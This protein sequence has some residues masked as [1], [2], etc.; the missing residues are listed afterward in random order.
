[1]W[2][3]RGIGRIFWVSSLGSIRCRIRFCLLG[4]C[5]PSPVR[6]IGTRLV[7]FSSG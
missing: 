4:D 3:S 5:L 6:K 1:M 7:D 2:R